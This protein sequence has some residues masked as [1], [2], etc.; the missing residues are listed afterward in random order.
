M[1]IAAEQGH[2]TSMYNV[3]KSYRTGANG[4]DRDPYKAAE[5]Y[6]AVIQRFLTEDCEDHNKQVSLRKKSPVPIKS[7]N[8]QCDI[9]ILYKQNRYAALPIS[10]SASCS[11]MVIS[12]RGMRLRRTSA[13]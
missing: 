8:I 1:R 10:I 11:P 5:L 3:A 6:R 9:Q 4:T 13:C 2:V 7:L 12:S